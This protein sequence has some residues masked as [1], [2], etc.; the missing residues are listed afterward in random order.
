MSFFDDDEVLMQG[1]LDYGKFLKN[2]ELSWDKF[3]NE[4]IAPRL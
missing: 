3:H 2:E 4:M 1:V